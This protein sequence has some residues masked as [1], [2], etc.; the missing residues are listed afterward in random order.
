MSVPHLLLVDDSESALALLRS[1]LAQ[2]YVLS[3]AMNGIE[4]LAQMRRGRPAAVLLD[5]SMPEMDGEE[6]L[7]RM[8]ADPELAGVPVVVVSSERER[9][10]ACLRLGAAAFVHKPYRRD[11]LMVTVGRVLAARGPALHGGVAILPLGVGTL[12]LALDLV[13]VRL[14]VSMVATRPLSGG[15]PYLQHYFDLHGDRIAV[16]DLAARL[17]VAH[18]EPI[19]EWKLVVVDDDQVPLAL[20]VDRVRDPEEIAGA[21]VVRMTGGGAGDEPFAALVATAHGRLPVV[22]PGLLIAPE[23]RGR[24][25]ALVA[26]GRG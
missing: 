22:N 10:E 2:H 19:V 18:A 14:V 12:E 11:E 21:D 9:G 25:P 26:Q 4:A 20:C 6:V 17:G 15:P 1:V 24:L 7:A 13:H 5:L 3:T 16:V 8:V 23:L